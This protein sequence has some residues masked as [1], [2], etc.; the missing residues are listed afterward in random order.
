MLYAGSFASVQVY[1][2]VLRMWYDK[3]EISEESC[4]WMGNLTGKNSKTAL[5]NNNYLKMVI[6]PSNSHDA[7]SNRG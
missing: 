2:L 4:Q 3:K 5:L 6:G 1:M 7:V